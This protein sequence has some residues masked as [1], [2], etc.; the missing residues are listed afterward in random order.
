MM[1]LPW[2]LDEKNKRYIA[3]YPPEQQAAAVLTYASFYNNSY[4]VPCIA[5]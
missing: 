3:E 5:A 1:V 4:K 2:V